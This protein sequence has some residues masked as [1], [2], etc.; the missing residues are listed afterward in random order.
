MKALTQQ[1]KGNGVARVGD[2]SERTQPRLSGS[3]NRRHTPSLS[4]TRSYG[5]GDSDPPVEKSCVQ[6]SSYYPSR[7]PTSS[8]YS[9][10]ASSEDWRDV[11]KERARR[12]EVQRVTALQ[13]LSY[14]G[15]ASEEVIMPPPRSVVPVPLDKDLARLSA[16][17][18]SLEIETTLLPASFHQPKFMLYDIS[19][20]R[21]VM[22]GYKCNDALMCLIFPSNLGELGLKWFERLSEDSIE[23][24]Q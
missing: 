8:R 21:Q 12:R 5:V 23:R 15:R 10:S 13:R 22:A 24:W 11:L 6:D 9:Y 16:T 17:P 18:F 3:Q 2:H 19:H 7:P 1:V 20:F 4:I 14:G